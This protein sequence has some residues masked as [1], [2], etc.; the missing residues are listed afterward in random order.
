MG[1]KLGLTLKDVVD[2][3]SAI[4]DEAIHRPKDAVG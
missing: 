2:T 4:A 3:A 1:R